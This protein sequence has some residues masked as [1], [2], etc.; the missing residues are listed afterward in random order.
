[1]RILGVVF[2]GKINL[3]LNK[4]ILVGILAMLALDL[5][6]ESNVRN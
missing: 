6:E 1:M 4:L 2:R 5:I 3:I